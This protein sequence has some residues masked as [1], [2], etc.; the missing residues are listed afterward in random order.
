MFAYGT[1][2][3]ANLNLKASAP[4]VCVDIEALNT[5]VNATVYTWPCGSGSG[6]NQLWTLGPAFIRSNMNPGQK[7][8]RAGYPGEPAALGVRVTTAVCDAADGGQTLVFDAATGLITHTPT[9][10][11]V[12]A[13]TKL[14]WCDAHRGW[15]VCDATAGL[16]ARA[17]DIVA[18]M[19]LA[20]KIAALNTDTPELPSIGLPR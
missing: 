15:T 3:A 17:A 14:S 18:R 9:G 7:C 10:L 16:D 6:D 20:D 4:A 2:R 13:G 11:C 12:D 19:T 1:P 8:L 5:G